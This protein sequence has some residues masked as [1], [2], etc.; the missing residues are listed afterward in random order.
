M[1]PFYFYHSSKTSDLHLRI[2]KT[3]SGMRSI[4]LLLGKVHYI[5]YKENVDHCHFPLTFRQLIA[6]YKPEPEV[7]CGCGEEA[8]LP[9]EF[10]KFSSAQT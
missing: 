8:V 4:S 9:C 3:V 10:N 5:T 6:I 7:T 2:S 1:V